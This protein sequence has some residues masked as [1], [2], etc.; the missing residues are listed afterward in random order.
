MN[1]PAAPRKVVF[2]ESA[3]VVLVRGHGASLQ[4][5]WVRRSDAVPVLPGFMAF[6]GGKVEPHDAGLALPGIEDDA[7]RAAHVCA[8]REAL[9]EAGVL[10]GLAPGVPAPGTAVLADARARLLADRATLADLAREHGWRFDPAAL[11]FAGR[12]QTPPFAQQRFDALYILA[13]VPDG[14]EPSIV[15]GELAAGEWVDAA[16]AI[17][18]WR[19]G[20]V[21]FVAPIL[22]A[23]RAIAEGE[24]RLAERLADAPRRAAEPA[25]LIEMQ[26]GIALH[27]MKTRPLPPATHTN[28]YFVGESEMALVD[29]G[30]GESEALAELFAVADLLATQGRRVAAIVVTHHHPDHTGGVAACR[31]RFRAPVAGHAALGAHLALDRTLA[32]GDTLALAAG[33]GAWDLRVLETPGHTRDSLSLWHERTGALFCGDLVPGGSGT[34]VIDPPDGDMAAYMAS[35]ERIAALPA[36]TLYPAHGSPAGAVARRVD[37]LAEHRRA[38]ERKVLAALSAH[39]AATLAELVPHAYADTPRELWSWAERSLLAH[40]LWLEA[41]GEAVREGER[42]RRAEAS[43][44]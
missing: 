14:Q 12:W 22:W 30:S 6:V 37:A 29:P 15:P 10:V 7:L 23:L 31:E 36:R 8:I 38:R 20:E 19:R 41:R 42:W 13:R 33:V 9:E 17:G 34:V 35:L 5:W 11:E 43:R 28:A 40:L 18:R 26:Y 4:V 39:A 21:A 24:E 3:V 16:D 2:R 32:D 25:R 1:E 27:A 44:A